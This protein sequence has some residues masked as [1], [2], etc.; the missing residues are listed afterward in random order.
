MAMCVELTSLA[1]AAG[2][3]QSPLLQLLLS[4]KLT[5]EI[6]KSRNKYHKSQ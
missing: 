5:R 4:L 3:H 2:T 6:M 1:N